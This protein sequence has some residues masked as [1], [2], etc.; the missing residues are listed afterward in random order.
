M[1]LSKLEKDIK[2]KDEEIKD[3]IVME[4]REQ[5]LEIRLGTKLDLFGNME[6]MN[7][8]AVNNQTNQ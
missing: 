7:E 6:L 3:I 1:R 8:R 5:R 2:F 4:N